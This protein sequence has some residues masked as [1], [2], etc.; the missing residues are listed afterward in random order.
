M[1]KEMNEMGYFQSFW[2]F[3][4][5]II[6]Q[7]FVYKFLR[8]IYDGISGAWKRSCITEFF[9]REHFSEEALGS[10]IVGRVLRSPF[11]FFGWL[12]LKC[13]PGL[14]AK[15]ETSRLVNLANVYLHNLLALNTRFIGMLAVGVSV[16][17]AISLEINGVTPPVICVVLLVFGGMVSIPNLN[18][19]S[20]LKGSGFMKLFSYLFGIDMIYHFFKESYTR[21]FSRLT[22][23][24][25][26]GIAAGFAGGFA[27]PIYAAVV[28]CGLFA[29]FLIMKSVR[30][31]V[32][33]TVFLAPLMPTMVM[34]ALTLLCLF[35]LIINSLIAKE[36]KWRFEGVGFLILGFLAVYLFASI[37]SF[38]MVNSL[39]ILAVYIAFML[40]YFVVI[41]TIKT[42]K[43]LFDVL[44][45]FAISGALV[46]LYGIAQYVFGWD[47]ASAWVDEEM[48]TDIKMRVYSTLENPNVLGEY[49]LLVLPVCVALIWQKSKALPKLVY[50]AMAVVM[51]ATLILTFS[52]GCWIGVMITAG[53]F[54][55]FVCGKLWGLA[56][57]ALPFIPMV[58]PESIINRFASVGDMKDSST[59]YRVYI[60][61]GTLAMIKDFWA[62]GIG[63]GTEAFKSVY[64]FYSY[65]GIVAPHSHNMFLQ[66]FVESGI[67]GI[68]VFLAV[69]FMFMKKMVTGYQ[70]TS[71]KGSKLGAMIV[72]IAAGVVGFAVQGMFDN[73][74]Y[75]YRVFLI[76]WYVIA[77]GVAA[78][79]IAKSEG[80]NGEKAVKRK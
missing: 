60:W 78:V 63:P 8:K 59:S 56:L 3:L 68:G 76:F 41:N 32:Y 73:C 17:L 36:F 18:L 6:K 75:N 49:I 2:M 24:T 70:A 61:F 22:F 37:N 12:K 38:A 15:A 26:I 31:G 44:S 42:R 40:F 23:A 21:P 27:G 4:W 71:G 9:R 77:L 65:S 7:S 28:I 74:F 5:G 33:M 67:V 45:L 16:G 64:P 51:F 29:F 50:I 54:V 80:R 66:I 30:A 14:K 34:V 57:I 13:G 58:I 72:A 25:I 11:T 79:H 52:R 69:L 1:I 19:T 43:Q 53:I 35:S 39:S 46:C 47:T 62:S 55:T 10:S 20:Y 48:F